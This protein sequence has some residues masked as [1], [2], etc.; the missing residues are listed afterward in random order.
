[1]MLGQAYGAFGRHNSEYALF[2]GMY[3]DTSHKKKMFV[4]EKNIRSEIFMWSLIS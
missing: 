1:M 4:R 3:A 2:S